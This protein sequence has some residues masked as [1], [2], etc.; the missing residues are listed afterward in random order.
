MKHHKVK[1]LWRLRP[2]KLPL[3][4]KP[5]TGS[6]K[7][8]KRKSPKHLMD[9]LRFGIK[10]LTMYARWV[11]FDRSNSWM[12]L[13]WTLNRLDKQVEKLDKLLGTLLH[14]D[15]TESEGLK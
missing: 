7:R 2:D 8:L 1:G 12:E 14:P 4:D 10:E 3:E 6:S 9:L 5:S 13:G 11:T 15:D